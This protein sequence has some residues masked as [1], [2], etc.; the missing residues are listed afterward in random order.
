MIEHRILKAGELD[1]G[2]LLSQKETR[3][4]GDRRRA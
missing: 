2:A 4:A 3:I 1:R